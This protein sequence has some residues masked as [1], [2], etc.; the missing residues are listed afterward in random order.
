M[1]V[2]TCRSNQLRGARELSLKRPTEEF[3]NYVGGS[4]GAWEV[5]AFSALRGEPLATVTHVDIVNGRLDRIPAG[6][7]WIL[8]GLVRN[9]RYVT[10]EELVPP[11]KRR[12]AAHS[13]SPTCAALIP[14]R[15]SAAWWDLDVEAR[16]E[17]QHPQSQRAPFGLQYLQYLSA[18]IHRWQHRRDLS[19]QLDNVTWF[20]YEPRDATA[21]DDL[22]ADWR[23]SE[24]WTYIDREC[25]IRLV[26]A[27]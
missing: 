10:R 21:F 2:I 22:L 26:R 13:P 14:I 25:D 6:A 8:S 18:M 19:D 20:E 24:E 27:A 15:R 16:R 4:S 7:S 1:S 17:L 23:A 5:T 9:T 11:G 12:F 3:Y